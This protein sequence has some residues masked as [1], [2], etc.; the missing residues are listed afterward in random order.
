MAK[1][2][3]RVLRRPDEFKRCYQRGRMLKN[4]LVV[5]HVYYRGDGERTRIGYSVSRRIGKA[6]ARNRVKRWMKESMHPVH[7]YLKEG[8]DLVFSARIPTVEA[9][10]WAIQEAMHDL[11]KRAG[12][13][14]KE[15]DSR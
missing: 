7:G 8:F 2:R 4:R 14:R 15:E 10:Y 11:L 13:L 1:E 6:V 5:L 12:M 3:V 9:G